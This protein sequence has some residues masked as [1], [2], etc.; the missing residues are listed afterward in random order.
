MRYYHVLEDAENVNVAEWYDGKMMNY[1]R[2]SFE[3]GYEPFQFCEGCV[4]RVATV[5]IKAQKQS[6]NLHI[7]PS[8]QC[9][10]F[11]SACICTIERLSNNP[12]PRKHLK[13]S[14]FSKVVNEFA[15]SKVN[16]DS[17]AFVGLGEPLFNSDLPAMAQLSRTLFP[18]AR[19]YA[20]TNCNFG[21]RRAK[22]IANCGLSDIRL[23][24]DGV[25][26]EAYVKY[27]RAGKFDKAFEFAKTLADEVRK[28][29]SPT[30]LTWK[31]ILFRHNDTDEEILQAVDLAKQIGVEIDFDATYGDLASKRDMDDI[32]AIVR[33]SANTTTNLDPIVMSHIAA[34]ASRRSVWPKLLDRAAA[35][36]SRK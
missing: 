31:Y 7:E 8:S 35:I 33:T 15:Q 19:I 23:S 13:L 6:V 25:T 24:L 26:Q 36:F 28:T 16:V 11:C 2:E 9:N 34:T 12:P 10:L 32:R 18:R 27:R 30:K 14:T 17:I 5:D 22:E 20:D 4:W 3:A 21:A 1:I 29:G